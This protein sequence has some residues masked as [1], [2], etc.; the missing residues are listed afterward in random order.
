MVI[1][2]VLLDFGEGI[3]LGDVFE[4]FVVEGDVVEYE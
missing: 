2:I 1:D 3:E 4:V